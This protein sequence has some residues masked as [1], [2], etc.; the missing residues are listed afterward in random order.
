MDLK[1][2]SFN[3][4]SFNDEKAY[5]ISF[6]LNSLGIQ[7]FFL[8]EHFLLKSN[9]YKVK[10]K[11]QNFDSFCLP[12][13]RTE[14]NEC[15]GRPSGGLG[16]FWVKTLTNFVKIIKH[17]DSNRVQGIEIFK[18]YVFINVYFPTDPKTDNFDD[19]ELLKCLEDINW[20]YDN[21]PNHN[22]IIG[23]DFNVDLSRNTRFVNIVRDF[24][25][26]K[27]LFTVWSQFDIDFTFGQHF[28]RNGNNYFVTSCID[29]FILQNNM[30]ND[31][32]HA[33][34]LHLG[35]NLSGHEPIFMSLKIEQNNEFYHDHESD[36]IESKPLWS[37]ASTDNIENYRTELKSGLDDVTI[38]E[39]LKCNDI[40]CTN[41]QHHVDMEKFYYLLT[42]LIDSSEKTI[43]QCRILAKLLKI[44]LCLGGMI[45]L[46]LFGRM[47]NFGM[48]F[49][50]H[51]AAL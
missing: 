13:I 19:F 28:N 2:L 40:N 3:S 41:P 37:K 6:L 9:L 1:T 49:G 20:Y 47:Q 14:R 22:F 45:K 25:I 29:H 42:D 46:D 5:F 21:M 17:P 23:G 18:K 16:I 32:S 36:K 4:S 51:L 31:V 38:T 30:L 34:A 12:A 15:I 33:Q 43:F 39:G 26:N 27:N 35:D 24:F 50:F 48:L 11:F 7:I 10:S 44:M 8:Q